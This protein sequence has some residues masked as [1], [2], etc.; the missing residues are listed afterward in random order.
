MNLLLKVQVFPSVR[1][2]NVNRRMFWSVLFLQQRESN[3][4]T[5]ETKKELL[6]LFAKADFAKEAC[7]AACVTDALRFA[8]SFATSLVSS[9]KRFVSEW[10][11]ASSSISSAR[12][13]DTRKW[14]LCR[15]ELIGRVLVWLES[16]YLRSWLSSK[17][18]MQV[19]LC[20]A[21]ENSIHP[22]T[23]RSCTGYICVWAMHRWLVLEREVSANSTKAWPGKHRVFFSK[24]FIVA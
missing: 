4:S 10:T 6:T 5:T 9:G 24:R 12:D 7:I 11:P 22:I 14:R 23:S 17:S 15:T 16:R 21:H 8:R 20:D 13:R 1:V 2:Q 3:S 18:V 19:L